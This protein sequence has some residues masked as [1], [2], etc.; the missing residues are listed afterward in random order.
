MTQR[1]L[2]SCPDCG[3][4]DL[5]VIIEVGASLLCFLERPHVSVHDGG[6]LLVVPKRH[7]ADRRELHPQ[8]AADVFL[9]SLVAADALTAAIGTDWFNF[10]ENGNWAVGDGRKPHMHLHV[11]GR[12]VHAVMQPFGE[13]LRFPA[14]LERDLWSLEP[15]SPVVVD[16]ITA[17]ARSALRTREGVYRG[18]SGG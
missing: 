9:A 1:N 6:H 12:S 7:V 3:L 11:Y 5:Y 2:H 15:M 4:T 8:E 16:A 13:A 14:R 10:Q 18:K 17:A